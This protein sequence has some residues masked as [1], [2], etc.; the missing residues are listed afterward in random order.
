[1]YFQCTLGAIFIVFILCVHCDNAGIKN[2]I[3]EIYVPSAPQNLTANRVTSDEI[4]LS[5]APPATYTKHLLD[6]TDKTPKSEPEL[7]VIAKK[8][9]QADAPINESTDRTEPETLI[10]TERLKD[11]Y[12]YNLYRNDKL[13]Y[14]DDFSASDILTDSYRSKRELRS[15]RHRKR[16]QN[17]ATDST[18]EK[19]LEGI[20]THQAFV[21]PIEVVKKS[22]N[23]A[24]VDIT[25]IAYVLYYEEGVAIRNATSDVVFVAGVPTSADIRRRN[26]FRSD[27]AMDGYLNAT[28]N[29]TLLNT[30]GVPT[31]V[32][33]FRLKNLKP[34]TPYKIWVRAFY[35]FQL[36]GVKSQDLLERLGP[37]SESLY[38]L[39]DVK[40]P[41]APIILN[42]TCDLLKGK[43]YLQ[44]RQPQY[45]NNS[46]D[47]YVN[48]EL[49][50]LTRYEVKIYAVTLSVARPN[51]LINGS[52][53]PPKHSII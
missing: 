29:L 15:H 49:W 31:K 39:S 2:E 48:V 27:F 44:W 52:E 17:N 1:M 16:R 21:L 46:L 4:H 34:F 53:S 47:Q 9:T 24:R 26:V 12:T 23:Q 28:R 7:T 20:E 14:N 30:S 40:P 11:G 33:G 50:N 43:L 35:N 38:V 8:E 10:K 25:Q 45:Y 3:L 32:V 5:W 6:S 41:S 22:F 19:S 37:Q 18:H 36:T 42:L 13:K 51:T